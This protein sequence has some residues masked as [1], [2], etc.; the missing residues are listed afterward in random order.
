MASALR[1]CTHVLESC[2]RCQSVSQSLHKWP[3]M[4]RLY[5]ETH[6]VLSAHQVCHQTSSQRY[7]RSFP[8][9][10]LVKCCSFSQIRSW[11]TVQWRDCQW[12]VLYI[13]DLFWRTSGTNS[14]SVSLCNV[15]IMPH[16]KSQLPDTALLLMVICL[17]LV[18]D[19]FFFWIC[20]H[21]RLLGVIL[22]LTYII[23]YT[24][25]FVGI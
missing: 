6:C 25:I 21:C 11:R 18:G 5:A 24:Y 4:I 20:R 9:T 2:L 15:F 19:A 8:D 22:P 23:H 10:G 12:N 14:H 3:E 7:S 17:H 1:G 16:R 13:V